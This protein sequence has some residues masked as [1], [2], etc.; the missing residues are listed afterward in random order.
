MTTTFTSWRSLKKS[1]Q[2]FPKCLS[3]SSNWAT[4]QRW[5]ASPHPIQTTSIS[6]PLRMIPLP[7]SNHTHGPLL[8]SFSQIY[9]LSLQSPHCVE[10]HRIF[11][12]ECT[13]AFLPGDEGDKLRYVETACVCVLCV[14]M[15]Q[16]SPSHYWSFPTCLCALSLSI[17]FDSIYCLPLPRSELDNLATQYNKRIVEV[18]LRSLCHH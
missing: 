13:C 2:R 15:F 12:I 5:S 10:V 17:T 11:P 3:T 4:F 16:P 14:C 18:S 7:P 8:L 9:K 1:G 6:S